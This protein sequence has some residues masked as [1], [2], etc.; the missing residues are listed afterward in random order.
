M[1]TISDVSPNSLKENL[2]E[3]MKMGPVTI[4]L[5]DASKNQIRADFISLT[6]KI[7]Q[8]GFY[9]CQI[10]S[11]YEF[12]SEVVVGVD[13]WNEYTLSIHQCD[14]ITLIS[15]NGGEDYQAGQKITVS[16]KADSLLGELSYYYS[17]NN[18]L[19]WRELGDTKPVV[20]RGNG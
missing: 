2:F 20:I 17:I 4:R 6:C 7:S 14:P 3:D 11:E 10:S 5:Y 13:C 1:V 12:S 8:S 18:G 9:Y 15:P 19:S 16:V